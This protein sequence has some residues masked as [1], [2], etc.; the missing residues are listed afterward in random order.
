MA[1]I[2]AL[3]V[4]ARKML[5][6][7]NLVIL[8]LVVVGIISLFVGARFGLILALGL[9]LGMTL[10]G[11]RFGFADRGVLLFCAASRPDSSRSWWLSA[12]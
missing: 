4:G 7:T 6:R 11:L 1:L 10:E 5:M 12:S 2:S 8:L 3:P 9:A